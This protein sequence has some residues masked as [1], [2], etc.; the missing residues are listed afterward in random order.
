[1]ATGKNEFYGVEWSRWSGGRSLSKRDNNPSDSVGISKKYKG[2]DATGLYNVKRIAEVAD[3]AVVL[4]IA[5]LKQKYSTA[6]IR[7]SR[8]EARKGATAFKN[9]K[10][11]RDANRARYHKILADKAASLPL[12]KMVEEAIDKLAKQISDGLKKGEKTQYDEI[13][14]GVSPKGREVKAR[15]ASAHMSS[16]LDD[17][18]RYVSYIKQAEESEER[19]GDRE[20]YYERESKDY[21]KRVK[22]KVAKVDTFDYAW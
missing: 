14:I 18:S 1:M 15:D 11:F 5:L 17:Y 12:D 10:D 7:A 3:R 20:S 8:E 22:E 21:A 4:N 2:W 9:D 19:Y 16:I 6:E 13:K